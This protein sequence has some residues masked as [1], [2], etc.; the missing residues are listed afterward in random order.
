MLLVHG[1]ARAENCE[2]NLEQEIMDNIPQSVEKH[3]PHNAQAEASSLKLASDALGNMPMND[4]QLDQAAN[5]VYDRIAQWYD[6]SNGSKFDLNS[7]RDV[8]EKALKSNK[9]DALIQKIDEKIWSP[10]GIHHLNIRTEDG[11]PIGHAISKRVILEANHTGREISHL[12]LHKMISDPMP[13]REGIGVCLDC[14]PP[15]DLPQ[16][17]PPP[18]KR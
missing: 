17:P 3:E 15:I 16:D 2:T 12:D 8:F 7:S 18:K 11:P 1:A 4:R 10:D 5:T 14:N 6:S 13:K 9:L